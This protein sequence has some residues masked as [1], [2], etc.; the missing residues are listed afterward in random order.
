MSEFGFFVGLANYN[1]ELN[2]EKFMTTDAGGLHFAALYRYNLNKRYALKGMLGLG[3]LKGN[4]AIADLEFGQQRIAEF[5][6]QLLEFTGQI[7]FN[8]M[9]YELGNPSYP[10]SPYIFVG[11]STF[12]YNPETLQDGSVIRPSDDPIWS[13]AV[14]FGV[15]FKLNLFGRL[16]MSAEWGFRKTFVDDIDGLPNQNKRRLSYENGKDYDNDWYSIVGI[17]L[18]YRLTKRSFCPSNF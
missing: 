17:S 3:S 5:E 1:G 8:F 6:S 18:N 11:F 9:E 14:P 7:E 16:G 12:R 10:F 2:P 15:G 4:D 13:V